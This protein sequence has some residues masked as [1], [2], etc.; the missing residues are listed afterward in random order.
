MIQSWPLFFVFC[1]EFSNFFALKVLTKI[2]KARRPYK[3]L[4]SIAAGLLAAGWLVYQW[5]IKHQSL[6]PQAWEN[7]LRDGRVWLITALLAGLNWT[8]RIL[9][10]QQLVSVYYPVGWKQAACQILKTYTWSVATPFNSGEFVGKAFFYDRLRKKIP[11]LVAAEQA[12]QMAVTVL[13]GSFGWAAGH[14][15]AWALAGLMPVSLKAGPHT[16][17]IAATS[18]FW[19]AVRYLIFAGLFALLLAWTSPLSWIQ[20]WRGVTLYYLAV[21][22]FPLWIW[23]DWAVK[24]SV[25]LAVF[26]PMGVAPATVL[27]VVFWLWIWQTLLPVG[28]GWILQLKAKQCGYVA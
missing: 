23:T 4:F 19:S 21:S 13:A 27:A 25:A 9:K 6:D 20:A 26:G 16:G 1:K 2:H 5:K 18:L 8:V 22:F 14:W 15:A 12:G 28:L 3:P 24:G 7:L 11:A 10:W 17:K